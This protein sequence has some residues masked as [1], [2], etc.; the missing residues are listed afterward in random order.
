LEV[1]VKV[2]RYVNQVKGEARWT[3]GSLRKSPA[4]HDKHAAGVEI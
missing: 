1:K 2:S 4:E 3:C